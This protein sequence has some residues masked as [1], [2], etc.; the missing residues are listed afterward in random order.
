MHRA[1]FTIALLSGGLFDYS[2]DTGILSC[3][4]KQ[5][6]IRKPPALPRSGIACFVGNLAHVVKC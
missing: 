3:F 5:A 6:A 2:Q 1:K 4:I